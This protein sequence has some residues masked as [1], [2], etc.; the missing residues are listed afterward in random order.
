M[1]PAAGEAVARGPSDPQRAAEASRAIETGRGV[2]INEDRIKAAIA[3]ERAAQFPDL[4]RRLHP[5]RSFRVEIPEFLQL[6]ILLFRQNPD[7][8][9]GSHIER[10]PRRMNALLFPRLLAFMVVTNTSAAFRSFRRAI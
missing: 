5:A 10:V 8:H 6:S 3:E 4:R 9:G 1:L 2:V 7:A